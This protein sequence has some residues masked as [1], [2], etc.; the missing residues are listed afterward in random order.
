MASATTTEGQRED[1]EEHGGHASVGF[2]WM[3]GGILA[4]LTAM[5]VAVFYMDFGAV[6]APF[7]LALSAAKFALVVMFFMH[8]RFDSRIFTGLFLTG[9]VLAAVVVSAL[10][11]LYHVIPRYGA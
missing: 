3:I 7:L 5:E 11:L 10:F 6:E 1:R 4:V 2:Y 9:M 8:L